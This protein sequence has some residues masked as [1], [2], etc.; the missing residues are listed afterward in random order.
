MGSQRTHGEEVQRVFARERK[1]SGR[2]SV[3]C[4]TGLK[5]D[6]SRRAGHGEVGSSH[7]Y[8]ACLVF[9]ILASRSFS[10]VHQ[11]SGHALGLLAWGSTSERA[12]RNAHRFHILPNGQIIRSYMAFVAGTR[13]AIMAVIRCILAV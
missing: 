1:Q 10:E 6:M 3:P 8:V 13:D 4:G 2:P 5:E 12:N 7:G 9:F 11:E